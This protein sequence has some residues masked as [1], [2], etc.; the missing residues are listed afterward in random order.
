MEA[1]TKQSCDFTV[2]INGEN[3]HIVTMWRKTDREPAWYD[4]STCRNGVRFY[5][6]FTPNEVQS[7][8]VHGVAEEFCVDDSKNV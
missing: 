1:Q 5:R 8:A 3:W 7:P 6:I 4:G 2:K